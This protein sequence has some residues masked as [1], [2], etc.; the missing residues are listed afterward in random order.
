MLASSGRSK[1]VLRNKN[2]LSVLQLAVSMNALKYDLYNFI[3][4]TLK[5]LNNSF[6]II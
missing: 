2:N 1:R 5:Y 6:F 3:Q 4:P